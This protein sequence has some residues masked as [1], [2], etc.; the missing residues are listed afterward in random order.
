[1]FISRLKINFI[2]CSF[3][4]K[5]AKAPNILDHFGGIE[6]GS[7]Q[8]LLT[9]IKLAYFKT[10]EKYS[11]KL[12]LSD[13]ILLSLCK[14]KVFEVSRNIRDEQKVIKFSKSSCHAPSNLERC[15]TDNGLL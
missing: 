12:N 13:N 6:S 7:S 4:Q 5:H 1:M 2:S 8:S 3:P 9:K 11:R 15:Y 14:I 10:G